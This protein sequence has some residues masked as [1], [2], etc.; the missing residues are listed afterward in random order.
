MYY[1]IVKITLSKF[2]VY[3]AD[4]ESRQDEPDQ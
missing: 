2:G 3:A 4:F 1:V